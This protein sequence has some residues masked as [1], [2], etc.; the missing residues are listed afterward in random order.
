[1]SVEEH[2]L[3]AFA[4]SVDRAAKDLRAAYA[5]ANTYADLRATAIGA[6]RMRD[7]LQEDS[8]RSWMANLER[9]LPQPAGTAS[10]SDGREAVATVNAREQGEMGSDG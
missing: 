4:Q 7:W 3:D 6:A 9:V 1:M 10:V 8:E 5:Q 2:L